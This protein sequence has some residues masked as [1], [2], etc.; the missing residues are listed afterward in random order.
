MASLPYEVDATGALGRKYTV[1]GTGKPGGKKAVTIYP[2]TA[3]T[4]LPP[5]R[6]LA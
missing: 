6:L 3:K 4:P 1:S 2:P 5:D